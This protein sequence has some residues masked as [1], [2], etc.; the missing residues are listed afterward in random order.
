MHELFSDIYV[1][2]FWVCLGWALVVDLGSL[3]ARR[4]ASK[5][6]PKTTKQAYVPLNRL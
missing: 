5:R 4:R 3:F 2:L 6:R 1:I